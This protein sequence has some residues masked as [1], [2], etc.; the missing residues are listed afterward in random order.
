MSATIISPAAP[1]VGRTD[2]ESVYATAG[3]SLS[4]V[5]WADG[6]PSPALVN[7]LNAVAPSLIRCGARVAVVG[8]GLGDD[9][10]ELVQRGYDV[11]GFDVSETAINW[12]RER[13]PSCAD[14]FH[15][16]DLFDIPARWRRRFDLVVEINTIQALPIARREHTLPA[17]ADLVGQRGRLLIIARGARSPQAE[18]DG[19]PWAL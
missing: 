16:A 1:S 3:R 7:W 2:F 18:S 5:P 11:T 19:P 9:V 17:I 6:R 8:C 10:R 14:A 15:V 4:G 12:A 13:H